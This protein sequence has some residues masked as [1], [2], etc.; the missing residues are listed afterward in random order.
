[1]KKLFTLFLAP[2]LFALSYSGMAQTY[3]PVIVSGFNQDLIA[4]GSGGAN[5]AF[6]TTTISFDLAVPG[7]DNVMYSTDFRGNNNPNSPPPAGLP[8]NRI[9]NSVNLPGATYNLANYSGN[10]ALFLAGNGNFGTLTL[11]TPGVFSTIAILGSSAEGGSTFTTQLNFS[12]GS[13]F[14]TSFNVP[15]WFNGPNFAI[16]GIDR[17]TRTTISTGT[18]DDFEEIL[19]NPRL[20]DNLITLS[21]PYNNRILTSVTFTK[22]SDQ[23][24]TAILALTGITAVNAPAAPV[25]TAATSIGNNSATANWQSSPN[26]TSYFLD[27]SES[28]TFSTFVAGYNNLPVGNVLTKEITGLNQNTTYFYRIRASNNDGTSASSNTITFTTRADV[29]PSISC[30]ANISVGNAAGQCGANVTF[31]ASETA[32]IPASTITYSQQPGSFFPVGTTT[33]TATA[34]NSAGTSRCTFTVTVSDTQ[35]PTISCPANIDATATSA[36]GAAVTYAAPVGTDNC[37]GAVTTRIAGPPSGSTFPIGTTTV[38]HQVKDAADN[39]TQCSFTVTVTGVAP[40]ISCPTNI[41]VGNDAG[42]CGANVTFAASETAGIP[43][44][45]ITYSQQ[46]GSFFPIGT[47]TVTATA[48]NAVGTS[49]CTFTV[50]VSDTQKPTISCPADIDVMPTNFNGGV[51]TYAAPVG[52][53]NCPGATTTR[54]AGPPSGSTFPIG[55]TTVTYQVKDAAGNTTECSFRVSVTLP[56]CGPKDQYV[57]ICYYGVTQCVSEKIAERYL[58]LGATIGGCGSSNNGRIGAEESGDLPLQLALKAYPNP[59]HDLVTL[60]VLAPRAGEATIEV[61]DLTGRTRQT[62][63]E[64]LAEGPNEVEL[65]LGA[66]PAGLYLIRTVDAAGRQGVTKINK[67]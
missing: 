30:P 31:A 18:A 58:K 49:Q 39:T 12:D 26:A 57:T 1:M 22:T 28:S 23:G 27:V 24:R 52:T 34:T 41:S 21:P 11:Q 4:E 56:R 10:N 8:T 62:R 36:N 51:V 3:V 63:R 40:Q 54:I 55:T 59:V 19:D 60:E 61:L 66:L 44:S 32:G 46:P 42:Q 45:T 13:N 67:Q 53:D 20:Y 15:D 47:T 6:N 5:R 7:G 38:T 65:R 9:I 48:T 2:L 14:S 29:P 37:P 64:T 17:V 16:K 50:T 25:A 43:A 35:K 33:V